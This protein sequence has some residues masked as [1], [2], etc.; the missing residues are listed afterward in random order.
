MPTHRRNPQRKGEKMSA[1][2]IEVTGV[3][4][5]S[6]DRIFRGFLSG[7][8]H[9]EMTGGPAT[10]EEDGSFTA[11]DGYIQGRTLETQEHSLIVQAWR[12][13]QFP[14]EAPDSRLE[15]LLAAEGDGTRVTFRHSNIPAG[16]GV[17]YEGGWVQH[18]LDPMTA[19][20]ST[21]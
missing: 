18:Y 2:T 12:T 15:I 7:D 21:R 14:E 20:F 16:Q 17:S 6:A 4:P 3:V 9:T 13:A 5:A 11:W 10:V 1:D 8:G 19:H